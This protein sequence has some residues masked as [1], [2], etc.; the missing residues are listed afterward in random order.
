MGQT[1]LC[2]G[3]QNTSDLRFHIDHFRMLQNMRYSL[4]IQDGQLSGRKLTRFLLRN[5]IPLWSQEQIAD[6]LWLMVGRSS[7]LEM[8][9]KAA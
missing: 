8:I 3:L 6:G 4:D 7:C 1:H 2:W 9:G 5:H